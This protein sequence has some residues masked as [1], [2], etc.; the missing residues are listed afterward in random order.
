MPIRMST[1]RRSRWRTLSRR[2]FVIRARTPHT[3]KYFKPRQTHGVTSE[4]CV[5]PRSLCV[6][7]S[8][9]AFAA[10]SSL[11]S[12]CCL[13]SERRSQTPG[14][15]SAMLSLALTASHFGSKL[16]SSESMNTVLR[17]GAC[18]GDCCARLKIKITSA[19]GATETR[20][21]AHA[22]ERDGRIGGPENAHGRET[23]MSESV[24]VLLLFGRIRCVYLRAHCFYVP[25][26][27]HTSYSRAALGID[28]GLAVGQTRQCSRPI[29]SFFFS[30]GIFPFCM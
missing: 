25:F 4:A 30:S 23:S 19:D 18:V 7:S 9:L 21:A 6:S 16:L 13:R 11:C 14:P 24:S 1:S 12:L 5:S 10:L 8:S 22:T 17:R 15:A 3:Q 20:R 2:K 26:R 28:D 29:R 27:R